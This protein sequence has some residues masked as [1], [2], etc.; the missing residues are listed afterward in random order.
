MPIR[1][2]TIGL[3]RN[4]PNIAKKLKAELDLVY[5][6]LIGSENIIHQPLI[7]IGNKNENPVILNRND[8]DGER[9]IWAQEEVLGKWNVKVN[10]GKYNIKFKFVKPVEAGGI[11]LLET[12]GIVNRMENNENTDVLEIIDVHLPEYECELFS[13]YFIA[14]KKILPFWIELE[15]T[16]L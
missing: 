15:K 16:D 3:Y 8:A 5:Q 14:G 2:L 11:L 12:D 1:K 9:G 13:N 10:K 6:E 4:I 7:E